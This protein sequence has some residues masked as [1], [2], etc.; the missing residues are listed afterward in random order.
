[1][2]RNPKVAAL[3]AA[4]VLVPTGIAVAGCGSSSKTTTTA[5]STSTA[6][7]TTSPTTTGSGATTTTAPAAQTVDV[8]ADATGKLEFVQ[9][10]LTTKAGAV[11]FE[12]RNDSSVPHNLAIEGNGVNVGPSKT[13]TGGSTATLRADL[14]PGKYTF[15]CAVPGHR[16]A[17]MKG[18]L[19][20]T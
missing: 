8:T 14:K 20:V 12:L 10:T 17:G 13:V 3:I 1:M 11:T 4:S 15:Y 9:K 18:T 7:A 6:P 19:T 16:D 5:P 2:L